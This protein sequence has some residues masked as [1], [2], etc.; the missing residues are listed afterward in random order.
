MKTHDACT[1]KKIP[2]SEAEIKLL[3]GLPSY[4]VKVARQMQKENIDEI[5]QK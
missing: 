4:V 2:L 5:I 3:R 1:K